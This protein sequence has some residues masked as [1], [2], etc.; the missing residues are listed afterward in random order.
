MVLISR[1]SPS[2]TSKGSWKKLKPKSLKK[3]FPKVL[4]SS[5]LPS[6][7]SFLCC[8][9]CPQSN[10][11]IRSF[12]T[13]ITK[14]ASIPFTSRSLATALW[15]ISIYTLV[16]CGCCPTEFTL[17]QLG[18]QLKTKLLSSEATCLCWWTTFRITSFQWLRPRYW[19]TPGPE[20]QLLLSTTS[21]ISS[22]TTR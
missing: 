13:Q 5:Q 15:Q 4:R 14:K 16:F 17:P 19:W 2:T 22:R 7:P 12:K 1:T 21:I 6:T 9:P 3:T 11:T 8:S 20:M 18:V 10:S